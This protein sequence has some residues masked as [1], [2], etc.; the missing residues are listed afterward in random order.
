MIPV[1]FIL[2]TYVMGPEWC[3]QWED[4]DEFIERYYKSLREKARLQETTQSLEG[5]LKGEFKVEA[6]MSKEERPFHQKADAKDAVYF[7]NM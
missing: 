4:R 7:I 6:K 5:N 3:Y 2:L 1:G